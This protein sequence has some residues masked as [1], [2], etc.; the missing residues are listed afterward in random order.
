MFIVVL[1]AIGF[2]S[3][4]GALNKL[5]LSLIISSLSSSKSLALLLLPQLLLPNEES[6]SS[7]L[8]KFPPILLF[9]FLLEIESFFLTIDED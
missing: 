3:L 6:I 1:G 4:L 7:G 2:M 8:N 9:F 5:V